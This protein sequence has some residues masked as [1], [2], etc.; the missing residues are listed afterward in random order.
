MLVKHKM[1]ANPITVNPDQTISEVLDLM[2]T[3]D[4]H[5]LPV[6]DGGKLVG[7]VTQGVVAENSPSHLT[8]LSIHEMNYLLSK[9]KV[10]DIMIKKVV[11]I[12]P[13][14]LIEEAADIME[15][16]DIGCLPVTAKDS[17][18]LGI[19]TTGDILSAFVHFFGYHEEGT[20]IVL[21]ISENKVGVLSELGKVFADAGVNVSHFLISS[22]ADNEFIIRVTD[23]DKKKIEKLLES[24]GFTVV[25]VR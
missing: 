15:V 14:A 23:P 7:L 21:D 11:T 19:I 17:T 5:R 13:D 12:S 2:S 24:K 6:V 25:S 22:M 9:K 1:T 16:K 8:T 4:I 18:L 3:H 20:R 10:K